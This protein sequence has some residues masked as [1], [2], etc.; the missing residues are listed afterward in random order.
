MRPGLRLNRPS[1]APTALSLFGNVPSRM[2]T[3]LI[4]DLGTLQRLD[5]RGGDVQLRF[6]TALPMEEIALG[7]SIAVNGACLTVTSLGEAAFTA[8]ASVETLAVTSLGTLSVGSPVHLERALRLGDRLGG[9]LVQGHVDGVG[10]VVQ[11]ARDARAIQITVQLPTGLLPEV[12]PKGSITL[13]GV[14]LTVNA[15]DGANIRVTII[16]WTAAKT[17]LASW[18]PGRKVNVETDILGKYV[19]RQLQPG[20]GPRGLRTLLTEYGYIASEE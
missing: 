6:A 18:Q 19:V 15:V 16:P 14:S 10:H 17:T 12:V 13:D 8:D 1:G 9:H 7:D 2:F 11:V 5:R 20:D 3:G 4:E